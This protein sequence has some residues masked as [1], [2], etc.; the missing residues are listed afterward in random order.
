MNK[1]KKT[2]FQLLLQQVPP[3]TKKL[4]QKQDEIA[5][6]INSILQQKGLTQK[7]F[8]KK[9]G[10][11]ESQ[12]SKILSGNANMTLK[13]ISKIEAALGEDIISIPAVKSTLIPQ[14]HAAD[15]KK[16]YGLIKPHATPERG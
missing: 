9:T 15:Y 4:V 5:V 11:K 16:L 8:A 13:T 14:Y 6:L 3:E 2:K 10:M 12:L 7:E 1:M